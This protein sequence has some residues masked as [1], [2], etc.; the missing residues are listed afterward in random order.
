MATPSNMH[1]PYASAQM[2]HLDDDLPHRR[3]TLQVAESCGQLVEGERAADG[4][5]TGREAAR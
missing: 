4:G 3:P 1:M 2:S 5:G